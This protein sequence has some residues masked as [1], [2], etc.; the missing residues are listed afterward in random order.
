M[1]SSGGSGP[2]PMCI[3]M[4]DYPKLLLDQLQILRLSTQIY[5]LDLS[6]QGTHFKVHKI[7]LAA[8]STFFKV[9]FQ[10]IF[11]NIFFQFYFVS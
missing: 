2:G 8:A 9:C 4:K 7:V 1:L 5:D 6:V 11:L 3:Y 10:I